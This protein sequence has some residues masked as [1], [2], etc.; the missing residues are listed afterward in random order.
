M[1][2][3]ADPPERHPAAAGGTGEA[4]HLGS[5]AQE[6]E[7][8]VAALRARS[9]AARTP[10]PGPAAPGRSAPAQRSGPPEPSP[11]AGPDTPPDGSAGPHRSHGRPGSVRLDDPTAA[12]DTGADRPS[13]AP[14]PAERLVCGMCPACRA[15]AFVD[16]LPASTIGSL[17]DLVLMAGTALRRFADARDPA[18]GG[19]AAR[20]GGQPQTPP[21]EDD[22]D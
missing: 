5:V 4:P 14:G 16:A 15:A 9:A 6:A 1:A 22:R 2:S 10:A 19:G 7:R 11:A 18:A 13:P 21:V 20:P 8:L 3:A 12:D 17:A